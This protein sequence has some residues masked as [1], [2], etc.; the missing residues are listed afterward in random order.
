MKRQESN[1]PGWVCDSSVR[2]NLSRVETCSDVSLGVIDEALFCTAIDNSEKCHTIVQVKSRVFTEE[3]QLDEVMSQSP[4]SC[5]LMTGDVPIAHECLLMV[6]FQLHMN[7]V[8]L[9]KNGA[10]SWVLFVYMTADS[11]QLDR[12]TVF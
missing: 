6:T 9:R 12:S 11:R 10:T 1:P 4:R 3:H 8:S 2:G 7:V 5:V